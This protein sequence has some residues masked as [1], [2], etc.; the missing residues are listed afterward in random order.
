MGLYDQMASV[1]K[2]ELK[3]TCIAG[4]WMDGSTPV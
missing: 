1:V 2:K 3:K 4:I